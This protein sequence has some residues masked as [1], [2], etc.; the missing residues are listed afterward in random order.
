MPPLRIAI[1]G[2]GIAGGAAALMLARR[3]HE[4][5]V[6]ERAA[7]VGPVGAGFLLQPSGQAVLERLGLLPSVVAASERIEALRAYTASGRSLIDLGFQSTGASA[8]GVHR[9]LLFEALAES[10]RATPARIEL[11]F[12]VA[13]CRETS[14]GVFLSSTDHRE[15]GP[16]DLLV[17]ADGARSRLRTWMNPDRR[18]TLDPYAALWT[19]GRGTS[20]RGHLYQVTRDT[21]ELIGLLPLG[22]GRMNFFWGLAA[23]DWESLRQSSFERF[24]DRVLRLA[25]RAE[26]VLAGVDGFEA[27]VYGGYVRARPQRTGTA[28]IVLVG[29]AAHPMPP[30]LGQGVNLALLD[31]ESLA[32]ALDSSATVALA[33]DRHL[34]RRRRQT[35]FYAQLSRFSAPFFQSDLVPLGLLRDLGLPWMTRIPPLRRAMEE[36]VAGLRPGWWG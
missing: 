8:Y 7:S 1:A 21:R 16:F 33:L 28:R 26:E 15:V 4:V 18:E 23:R 35:R 22:G 19:V 25:P 12:E 30:H 17:A 13:S 14:D 6:F 31:V 9:G 27:F 34:H 20:V 24:R 5:T 36:T 32:E 11:A 3:G 2:F 29:D 10:V